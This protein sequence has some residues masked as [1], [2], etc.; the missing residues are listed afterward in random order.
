MRALQLSVQVQGEL[1]VKGKFFVTH[2]DVLA[3]TALDD[4]SGIDGLDNS[5]NGV[6]KVLNHDWFTRFNTCLKNL[7][8]LRVGKSRDL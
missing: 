1:W 3:L 2:L 8:H 4:G 5:V 6:L 7:D